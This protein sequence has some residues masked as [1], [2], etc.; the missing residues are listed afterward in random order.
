[1]VNVEGVYGGRIRLDKELFKDW[2]PG[3]GTAV[4]HLNDDG[5]IGIEWE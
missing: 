5:T 2:E 3:K 1:M 4:I